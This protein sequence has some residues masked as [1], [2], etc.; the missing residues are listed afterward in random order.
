MAKAIYSLKIWMF[1]SQFH[2]RKREETGLLEM[3][4]FIPAAHVKPWFTAPIA[5]Q[6]PLND[7][8]LLKL[9]HQESTR[10]NVWKVACEKFSSHLWY[11]SAELVGLSFFDDRIPADQKSRMVKALRERDMGEDLPK[12]ATLPASL[13]AQME[14]EDFVSK[15]TRGFFESM[16][17]ETAFMNKD[18]EDWEG[19]LSFQEGVAV[20]NKLQVVN[21]VAERMVA[22][23]TDFNKVLTK[24]EEQKQYL[25]QVVA[26]NRKKCPGVSK[27]DF[28]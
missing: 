16:G 2:L 27:K 28:M 7:L 17:I 11:L 10:S 9:L 19:E 26:E 12:R 24:D 8:Q 5:K 14:L 20:I 6:G 15:T 13:C 1:R 21:D 18:P 3:C 22:M 23:V 25:L 4:I